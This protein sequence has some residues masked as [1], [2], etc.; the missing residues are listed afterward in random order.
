MC[1]CDC[2][3]L[4]VDEPGDTWTVS[5]DRIVGTAL[6]AVIGWGTANVWH[7][8]AL[9][10]G[11]RHFAVHD[12]AP[13]DAAEECGKNGG[14]YGDDHHAD[15]ELSPV[16][17]CCSIEVPGSKPS[18]AGCPGVCR[19]RCGEGRP[20]LEN[21]IRGAG[22]QLGRQSFGGGGWSVEDVGGGEPGV[23]ELGDAVADLIELGNGMCVGVD[24]DFCSRVVW[25]GEDGDR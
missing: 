10:N 16:L 1:E 24:Y 2:E 19:G 17:A 12:G 23:T 11:S 20:R 15:S 18:C 13:G 3:V 5:Q 14:S 6:R 21:Q 7:E 4:K 22:A 25:R 8:N 9:V